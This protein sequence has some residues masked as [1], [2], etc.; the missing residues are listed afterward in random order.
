[1]PTTP[2]PIPLS[3]RKKLARLARLMA[4][5]TQGTMALEGQGVGR[6]ALDRL[7]RLL[8]A[9]ALVRRNG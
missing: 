6:A 3:E 2:V 8:Y 1:M 4:A 7:A 9:D 5:Y